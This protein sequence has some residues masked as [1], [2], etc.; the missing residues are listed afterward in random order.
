MRHNTDGVRC[1]AAGIR[2]NRLQIRRPRRVVC[3]KRLAGKQVVGSLGRMKAASRCL[4]LAAALS[5]CWVRSP[6][7]EPVELSVPLSDTLRRVAGNGKRSSHQTARIAYAV[8]PGFDPARPWPILVISATS[9]PSYNSSTLHLRDF[10]TAATAEGWVVVAADPPRPVPL[11]LD[12]NELRYALARAALAHLA[13]LWP[14]S[15]RWPLAF[16]GFS[17]GAKRSGWLAAM[18]ARDGRVPIGIFQGGCNAA[19]T[20]EAV[21]IYGPPRR[22]FRA[23]PVFLSSGEADGIATPGEHRM[24]ATVLRADGFSRV[25]FETYAGG[26]VLDPAHVG[27]ALRWFLATTQKEGAP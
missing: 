26:H 1:P 25:R 14:G 5:A 27:A 20:A 4:I 17:G 10:A 13:T 12:S 3:R 21:N 7:G 2:R 8:P 24:V 23:V 22:A 19:T 15:D 18:F 6:G 16:G 11:G 9:D